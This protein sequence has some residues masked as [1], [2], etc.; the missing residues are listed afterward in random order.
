MSKGDPDKET[1]ELATT[2]N[3]LR[4]ALEGAADGIVSTDGQGRI[5]SWNRRFLNI[6]GLPEELVS[7][8]DIQKVRGFIA[9]Q[10]K[11][12]GRYLARIAE[13]EASMKKALICLN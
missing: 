5:T 10:L 6:W 2:V 11:D 4:A 8:R 1:D 7:S 12:Q 13:I 9:Q 3:P